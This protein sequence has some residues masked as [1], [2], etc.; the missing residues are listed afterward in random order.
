MIGVEVSEKYSLYVTRL[1]G[2]ATQ[3]AGAV[4]ADIDHKQAFP[5][6]NCYAGPRRLGGGQRTACSTEGQMQA[7]IAVGGTLAKKESGG[8]KKASMP[9]WNMFRFL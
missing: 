1:I 4:S 3:V 2:H 5:G 9:W 7:I 6:H 8:E